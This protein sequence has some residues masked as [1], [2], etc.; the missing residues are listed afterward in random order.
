MASSKKKKKKKKH[1][2]KFFLALSDGLEPST[3][4][5][6]AG[7]ATDC[8][9]KAAKMKEIRTGML[10]NTTNG[11]RILADQRNINYVAVPPRTG[12]SGAFSKQCDML[13]LQTLEQSK[14]N[15]PAL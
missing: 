6:T 14:R 9:T 11:G 2:K 1:P 3:Y 10:I 8:A 4:R 15:R 12:K 13:L 7:R 5:L